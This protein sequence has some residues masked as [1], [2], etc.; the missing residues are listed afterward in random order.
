MPFGGSI[1]L[2]GESEYRKAISDITNNL[3]I[4]S[5]EMKIVDSNFDKTD[6]STEALSK[7]NE[8]LKKTLEQLKT[9]LDQ[10]TQSYNKLSSEVKTQEKEH[11]ALSK[12]YQKQKAVLDGMKGTLLEGTETY[13]K[14]AK[15][16]EDLGNQLK[17]SSTNIEANKNSLTKM[18]VEMNNVQA[19]Y[20]KTNNEIQ[21]NTKQIEDNKHNLDENKNSVNKLSS[22]LENQESAVDKAKEGFTVLKGVLANLVSQ[23]ISKAVNGLKQFASTMITTSAS[24]KAEN[25]KFE[26]TFGDMADQATNAIER[27]ANETGIVNTRLRDTASNI[28]AFARS[29]GA[30]VPEAMA[31]METALQA[32]ADSAA[33]YDK[34]LEESAD[35]LQSFLK[36][37]YANDAALGVSATEFTRNAKATELFGKKYNELSE[38]QKQQTLLKMVTDSQKLSGAMGQA[39]RETDGFENVTG[40]LK[41]TWRQFKAQ[42]GSKFLENLIPILKNVT[43]RFKEWAKSVDWDKFG[44]AVDKAFKILIDAF[45]WIMKNSKVII[46]AFVGI[47][48]AFATAKVISFGSAIAGVIKTLTGAPTIITGVK[49]AMEALNLTTLANPYVLLASAIAGV[50]AGLVAWGIASNNNKGTLE[51]ETENIKKQAEEIQKNKEAYEEMAETRQNAI[52]EGFSEMEYYQ[53]LAKELEKIVDENG[54]VKEGYEGRASFI[55]S[56]LKDALGVEIEYTDGVVKGYN[57]IKDSIDQLIEKKRAEIVLSAQ[58]EAYRTA[59][60]KRGEA[61]T[62]LNEIQKSINTKTKEY[63]NI[64]KQLATNADENGITLTASQ[65]TMKEN[66]LQTLDEQLQGYRDNYQQQKDIVAE[67]AYNIGQYETNMA[68]MHEG[69]YTEMTNVAWNHV[70]ALGESGDNKKA[71]LEEQ[72]A[73]ERSYLDTMLKSRQETNSNVLDGQI[74]NTQDIIANLEEQMKQYES[75]TETG[76]N[77][78]LVTW[79]NA[80]GN[81]LSE[82]TGKNIEFK[83]AGNGTVQM[84]ADGIK[85]GNPTATENMRQL[86]SDTIQKVKDG[87][88]SADQ[89]S[90]MILQGL[91]NGLSQE[92]K[93]R[94]ILDSMNTLGTNSISSLQRAVD[95]H[96]PSRETYAIGGYILDGMKNGIDRQDKRNSIFRSLSNFGG[97]LISNL[98]AKLGIASPSKETKKMGEF[99]IEGLNVGIDK[100]EDSTINKVKGFGQNVVGTLQDELNKSTATLGE[101]DFNKASSST[102]VK[103]NTSEQEMNNMNMVKAFVEALNQSQIEMGDG[104]VKFINKTVAKEIYS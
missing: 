6:T 48:T 28:Y 51:L 23:G 43:Q 69:K 21:K 88:A 22:A 66:L 40:N 33:Y 85:Q 104:F 24:I 68:L 72:L 97:S 86:V 67:Y 89:A 26:Q 46:S 16:V 14:Q 101:V 53:S 65:R 93:R 103:I 61:L 91:Y 12:E 90:Q 52:N 34:S 84:Y 35:T 98:K 54:K 19:Q 82:I 4:L 83:D 64:Q 95:A 18:N 30:T 29:S 9:K 47:I 41:E 2:T 96:S 62:T 79:Q 100:E 92:Q 44:K 39:S 36:G 25:A 70:K 38:I 17:K 74:K 42:V 10:A 20:D 60:Q 73:N 1:K 78:V 58:E 77:E 32:T 45:S 15:K 31:L 8:V 81:Q 71:L 80:L 99:L 59:I 49:T 27:V 94:M 11:D 75:T 55:T 102:K 3:K 5:S 63:E 87:E 76:T 50:I 7:R 57:N 13:Q 56:T 37:N